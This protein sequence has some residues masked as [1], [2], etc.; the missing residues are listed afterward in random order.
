MQD[1]VF[2][3]ENVEIL[4]NKV[5]VEATGDGKLL[6]ALE[7]QDTKTGEKSTVPVSGLFYAIG[8]VP[9]TN[10]LLD[11]DNK[12]QIKVDGT[13]YIITKPGTCL[14]SV[15]GVFAAGDVQ[16]KKYRQA[17]TAAGSGCM[18]ALDAEKYLETLH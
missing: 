11:A 8:H 13:G 9:N 7:L 16:D 3:N 18:A 17:V 6:K 4:W 1:R 10:L 5:P 15:E 14:T 12:H 2:K